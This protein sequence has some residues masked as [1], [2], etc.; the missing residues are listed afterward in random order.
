MDHT[1]AARNAHN[2]TDKKKTAVRFRIRLIAC[3]RTVNEC[4]YYNARHVRLEA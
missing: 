1:V 2:N 3:A 4:N